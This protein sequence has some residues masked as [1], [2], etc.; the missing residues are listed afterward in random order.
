MVDYKL[1]LYF[2][3][4]KIS[5]SGSDAC[6]VLVFTTFDSFHTRVFVSLY[7]GQCVFVCFSS[8]WVC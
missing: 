7:V 3:C 1:N 8:H 6:F 5:S 2:I 4:H